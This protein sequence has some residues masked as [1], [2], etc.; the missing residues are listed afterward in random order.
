M[1]IRLCWGL[2]CDGLIFYLGKVNLGDINLV[3]FI[4]LID[5]LYCIFNFRNKIYG[6]EKNLIL[7]NLIRDIYVFDLIK[8]FIF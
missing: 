6:L 7:I 8:Y 2:I 1:G 4:V 5:Y 3:L